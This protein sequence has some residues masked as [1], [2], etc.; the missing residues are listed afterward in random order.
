MLKIKKKKFK[1]L[2]FHVTKGHANWLK[3]RKQKLSGPS[4]DL[5]LSTAKLW[6]KSYLIRINWTGIWANIQYQLSAYT[7]VITHKSLI[8]RFSRIVFKVKDDQTLISDD[9]VMWDLFLPIWWNAL[10]WSLINA[11]KN[12]L[13]HRLWVQCLSLNFHYYIEWAFTAIFPTVCAVCPT[14]SVWVS[15]EW[16]RVEVGVGFNVQ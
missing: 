16:G 7:L 6:L 13:A 14:F 1:H 9:F 15:S 10:H 5:I 11:L 4:G 3:A 12:I 8:Q 2:R